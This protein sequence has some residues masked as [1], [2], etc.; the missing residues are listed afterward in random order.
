MRKTVRAIVVAF[1]RS[2]GLP[3]TAFAATEAGV[4][5]GCCSETFVEVFAYLR[6]RANLFAPGDYDHRPV[7]RNSGGTYKTR[8]SRSP[9]TGGGNWR[10]AAAGNFTSY[11]VRCYTAG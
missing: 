10:I 11:P 4:Q 8:S 7:W 5:Y 1:S 3:T 2:L 9:Y 6:G